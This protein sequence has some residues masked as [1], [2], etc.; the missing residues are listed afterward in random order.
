MIELIIIGSSILLGNIFI[1]SYKCIK[2]NI[3]NNI[4]NNDIINNNINNIDIVNNIN[5]ENNNFSVIYKYMKDEINEC[6]ICL[7]DI[8][9][10]D[11]IRHLKCFHIYHIDCIDD[12][13]SRKKI[14]PECNFELHI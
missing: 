10:Y 13:L 11:I 7:E 12:W 5:K 8:K 6:S 14:C 4:N 2:N 9:K 1:I 3:N